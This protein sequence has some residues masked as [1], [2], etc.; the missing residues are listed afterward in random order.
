MPVVRQWG[1]KL[2]RF[3]AREL[4]NR[5]IPHG[6]VSPFCCLPGR[7]GQG[8]IHRHFWLKAL[9]RVPR[10]V[11][12]LLEL[13]L[14]IRWT[15]FSAWGFTWRAVRQWG[16]GVREQSGMG[17]HEQFR[18]I[19]ALS[20][21][22]TIPP[23]EIYAFGLYARHRRKEILDYVFTHECN[24]YHGWQNQ[25]AGKS[26]NSI[27]IL[28]DK[29]RTAAILTSAG[30]PV[31]PVLIIVRQGRDFHPGVLAREYGRV[32]VKP[33]L[34]H[35]GLGCFVLA[36]VPGGYKIL[37]TRTGMVTTGSSKKRLR[38]AF[39]RED[40]L[41]QPFV[42]NH[43]E[44]AGICPG[45]DAVTVRVITRAEKG[46]SI[47]IYSAVLE[48]PSLPAGADTVHPLRHGRPGHIIRPIQPCSGKLGLLPAGQIFSPAP[49]GCAYRAGET[50]V[51]IKTV[52]FWHR[53]RETAGDAHACFR[54]I[55][56]IAWDYVISPD[57]PL[58]LEG[59]TGWDPR[60]PQWF[61]GGLLRRHTEKNFDLGEEVY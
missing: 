23:A 43:P 9:S 11:Y 31:V 24:A 8:R 26:G 10:P 56:A 13:F 27:S 61:H 28:R 12:L 33:R 22:Y 16:P 48:I 19:L 6:M 37:Q 7:S 5:H 34:G 2:G 50:G 47:Q 58:L 39:S 38:Q 54:D 15:C 14:Y 49:G 55:Y 4:M 3:V 35:A 32:F 44:L 57:G 29:A 17:L 25:T 42:A 59:N 20:I 1:I 30:L 53:I 45:D 21:L 52:P 51:N 60:V 36:P 40:Y 46:K 41:V 18:R